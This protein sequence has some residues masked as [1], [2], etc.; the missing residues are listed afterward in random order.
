MRHIFKEQHVYLNITGGLTLRD[1]VL[2]V[3]VSLAS[4]L[5]DI[6]LPADVCFIGEVGLAGEVRPAGRTMMRLK[7]ASRLGFKRQ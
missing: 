7:E 3:C 1:P 5:K 2:A 6:P 4:T